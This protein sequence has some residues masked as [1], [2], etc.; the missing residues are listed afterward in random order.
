MTVRK[1]IIVERGIRL[2]GALPRSYLFTIMDD[3]EVMALIAGED[4]LRLAE[5][6]G[7]A[8]EQD[9]DLREVP[10]LTQ[11]ASALIEVGQAAHVSSANSSWCGLLRS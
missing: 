9:E 4:L 1:V 11:C 10:I 8:I 3:Q 7:D 6:F 5:R 2:I